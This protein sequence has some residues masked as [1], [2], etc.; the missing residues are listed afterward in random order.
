MPADLYLPMRF[1]WGSTPAFSN[2]PLRNEPACASH[3]NA[4]LT[5]LRRHITLAHANKALVT[6]D[7]QAPQAQVACWG[8]IHLLCA[9]QVR[10]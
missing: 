10:A 6:C 9:Q 3:L 5:K 4:R 7:D 1:T 2:T 8:H